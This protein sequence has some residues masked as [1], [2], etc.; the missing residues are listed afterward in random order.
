M[1]DFGRTPAANRWNEGV[2]PKP[3]T[4][5]ITGA[6]TPEGAASGRQVGSSRH[7]LRRGLVEYAAGE[8]QRAS[9]ASRAA[10]SCVYSNANPDASSFSEDTR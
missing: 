1:P 9:A 7:L 5:V 8:A 4:G 2:R 10:S 3:D 6:S